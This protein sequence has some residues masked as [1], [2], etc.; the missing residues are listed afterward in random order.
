MDINLLLGIL[1]R[2]ER[3]S[4]NITIKKMSSDLNISESHLRNLE[5]DFRNFEINTLE[6]ILTYLEIPLE[7]LLKKEG[8][9]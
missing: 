8:A 4:Q 6:K 9:S 5:N 7:N 1:I 3:K 2:K